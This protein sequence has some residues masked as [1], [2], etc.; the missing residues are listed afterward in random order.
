[1]DIIKSGKS[2]KLT[3]KVYQTRTEMGV[4]AAKEAAEAINALIEKKGDINMIFAAAPSQN[5]FLAALINDKSIDF[6]KINAFHMDE[7]IGLPSDAPQGFGNFLRRAIFDKVPFNSVNTI[8]SSAQDAE[9]ECER[10]TEL[11]KKHPCDIVCMGI[12]ENGHIAFNDPHVADFND[13]KVVKVV[14]LDEVCRMQQVNDGC[15]KKLEDVPKYALTLTIPTL[16]AP[17][18]IFC[19]VPAKTKA[20]AVKATLEGPI[21]EKCPATVLR[22][23]SNAVLYLDSDS[24]SLI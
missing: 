13:E 14:S 22:N 1:M 5:E 20:N 9:T 4:A 17:E 21:S 23:H 16:I 19:M 15:F 2:D 10:Y 6:S 7:Y 11:L 24:A 18:Y 12:G 3:Y 8:D